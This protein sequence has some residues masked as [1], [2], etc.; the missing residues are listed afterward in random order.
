M[1]R[2]DK[3]VRIKFDDIYMGRDQRTAIGSVKVTNSALLMAKAG[4]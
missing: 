1:E 4:P 2:M 3:A